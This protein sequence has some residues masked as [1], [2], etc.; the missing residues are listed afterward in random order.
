MGT[1]LKKLNCMDYFNSPYSLKLPKSGGGGRG[2]KAHSAPPRDRPWRIVLLKVAYYA[3]AVLGILPNYANT[4][5][6]FPNYAPT[7]CQNSQIMPQHHARIPKLCPNTMPEFPNY[8]P[9]FRDY[10]HKMT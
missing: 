5:P 4:M 3:V 1:L 6:E 10:A 7:P 9:D 2:A 8:A